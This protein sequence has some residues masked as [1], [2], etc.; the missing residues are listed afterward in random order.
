MQTHCS[1]VVASLGK[2]LGQQN[3]AQFALLVGGPA[4]VPFEIAA[5]ILVY[6]LNVNP[7]A[8]ML[9]INRVSI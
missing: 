9:T 6:Q 5:L 4:I 2:L 8:L 7:T 3:I 1:N